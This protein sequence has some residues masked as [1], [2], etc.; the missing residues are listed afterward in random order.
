MK[1]K[2]VDY[3]GITSIIINYKFKFKDILARYTTDAIASCV[4]G[5]K[6]DALRDPNNEFRTMGRKLIEM[7][8]W[9]GFKTLFILFVPEVTIFIIVFIEKKKKK[10]LCVHRLVCV[11]V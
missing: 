10:L 2:L 3:F 6:S 5:V 1:P 11:Y 7:D 8:F 9:R 4:F